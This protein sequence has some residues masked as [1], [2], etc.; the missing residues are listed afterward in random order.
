MVVRLGH[1]PDPGPAA[2]LLR[3]AA[4]LIADAGR[5][6]GA[7]F[8]SLGASLGAGI[9]GAVRRRDANRAHADAM[10]NQRR[11]DER[12]ER[13]HAD[14]MASKAKDDARADKALQAQM[15]QGNFAVLTKMREAAMADVEV[16]QAAN[17]P[18][19]FARA[20]ARVQTVDAT[21]ATVGNRMMSAATDL[22]ADAGL[23]G[24]EGECLGGVCALPGAKPKAQDRAYLGSRAY[25]RVGAIQGFQKAEAGFG[26]AVDAEDAAKAKP[27][28]SNAAVDQAETAAR[29]R[30]QL[31]AKEKVYAK[32]KPGPVRDRLRVEIEAL[33]GRVGA[34]DEALRQLRLED[35]A[36]ARNAARF[37]REIAAYEASGW[38]QRAKFTPAEDGDI[39]RMIL[40]GTP[41]RGAVDEKIQQ[42]QPFG[43][44][45]KADA[46]AMRRVLVLE[47]EREFRLQRGM[48]LEPKHMTEQERNDYYAEIRERIYQ[49]R[50]RLGAADALAKS[51]AAADE[52]AI[53]AY[54]RELARSETKAVR[55]RGGFDWRR[56]DDGDKKRLVALM[57]T[58]VLTPEMKARIAKEGFS[59]PGA[60]G[61]P[62]REYTPGGRAQMAPPEPMPSEDGKA[63][64]A[65][66][67]KTLS[68]EEQTPEAWARI[69]AKHGVR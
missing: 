52:D 59:Q 39:R 16:A 3:A 28:G 51:E 61:P 21:I 41:W 67:F 2:G 34:A 66:E 69:K 37:E 58:D 18:E 50:K 25:D 38:S 57:D 60:M 15:D 35:N 43:E 47:S 14:S 46:E 40:N 32:A 20:T 68:A 10:A 7:G 36:Q 13:F 11:D 19:A 8:A 31:E 26:A 45:E 27:T 49:H 64:A 9:T 65:A 17:D 24:M 42:R 22:A 23:L 53:R 54:E 44:Q 48:P 6:R 29:L 63:A 4:D 33:S 55:E 5:A 62:E 12:A 1:A 30:A 56:I